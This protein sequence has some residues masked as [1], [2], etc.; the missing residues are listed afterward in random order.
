ME[1]MCDIVM[2]NDIKILPWVKT[3]RNAT[4]QMLT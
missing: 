4:F 2:L 3:Q 1:V